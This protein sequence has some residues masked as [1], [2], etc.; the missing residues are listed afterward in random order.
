MHKVTIPDYIIN[1]VVAQRGQLHVFEH[2]EARSTALLVVDLQNAFIQPGAR[3]EIPYAR[4]L[5]PNVNNLA[6]AA[7]AAGAKVVWLQMTLEN[8][9]DRWSVYFDHM[10]RAKNKAEDMKALSRGSPGHAL[11]AG[12]DVNA[13]DVIVEKTRF[14]AFIQGS[15]DLD[16]ILRNL[17]IDTLIIVGTVTNGCCECTARDAMMLNYKI[18][19]VSDGNAARSDDEHNAALSNI[20]RNFG[21]VVSTEEAIARLERT[22]SSPKHHDRAT[23]REA[24][25]LG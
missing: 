10:R 14:S 4:D 1:R 9:G 2:L 23:L 13:A 24:S 5:V 17:G 7:R 12:L 11:Y 6:R 21:D 8:E 18:I 15:S 19:F 16:Q 20:L 22:S 3:W 25:T